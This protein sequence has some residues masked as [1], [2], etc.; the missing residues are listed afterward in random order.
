[1]S[2]EPK[3]LPCPFCGGEARPTA[4]LAYSWF[5]P[6]CMSCGVRG[7]SV[8][9]DRNSSQQKL[10]ELMDKADDLWNTRA[11]DAKTKTASGY[12]E[13]LQD[14]AE[15]LVKRV[16]MKVDAYVMQHEA[17]RKAIMRILDDS[18][19]YRGGERG[20]DMGNLL[21]GIPSRPQR[22]DSTMEQLHDLVLVAN[23]LGMY[24]AADAIKQAFELGKFNNI[25]YGC[26]CDLEEGQEPDDCV[27][28]FGAHDSCVNARIG[29]RPEQCEHWRQITG[30]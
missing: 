7:P 17:M 11:E 25:R 5:A 23:R 28:N 20:E 14:E 26:H 19:V 16:N 2:D 18:G 29:M 9:I 3:L 22:Q 10:R 4:H 13:D 24:D 30:E 6:V 1:M 8:K 27:I 12:P 21:N 15:E